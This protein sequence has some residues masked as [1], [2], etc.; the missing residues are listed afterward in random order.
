MKF[1]K[2]T[3]VARGAATIVNMDLVQTMYRVTDQSGRYEPST[4]IQ[5]QN[6]EYINVTED[7]QTIL[8]LTQEFNAGKFQDTDW[9]DVPSVQQSLES[10]YNRRKERNYNRSDVFNDTRW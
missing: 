7:L 9:Q 2:L 4:K 10:A 5:F 1:L 8:K 3:H 6:G